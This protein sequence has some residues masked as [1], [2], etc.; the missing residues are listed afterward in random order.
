MSIIKQVRQTKKHHVLIISYRGA[1]VE[2]LYEILRNMPNSIFKVKH[3]IVSVGITN[4]GL[5]AYAT[6]KKQIG[7]LYF[8]AK[9]KFANA[10]I[11]YPR[12]GNQL[13][14]HRE[15]QNYKTNQ[16]KSRLY[17]HLFQSLGP[18]VI[19]STEHRRL[20]DVFWIYGWIVCL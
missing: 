9:K 4:R 17:F 6:A 15:M 2:D 1:K 14:F 11:Y 18:P 8:Q 3:L 12:I 10:K 16:A 19:G 13:S 7:N 5:N 20:P